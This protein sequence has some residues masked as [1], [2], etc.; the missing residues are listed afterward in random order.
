MHTEDHFERV[1]KLGHYI[2][3]R[4]GAD[5]KV[6]SL[7]AYFHDIRRRHDGFDDQHGNRAAQYLK[8]LYRNNLLDVSE[9][10]FEKLVFACA[11]HSDPHAESDD[12]TIQTCWDADRLDLWRVNNEP[13]P[14][15]LYTDIAKKEEA[16]EYAR[17]LNKK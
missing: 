13:D 14:N 5:K 12:I 9:E 4:N 6:I 16:I 15:L 11:N 1:Q 2:A 17:K 8:I 3:D 7:F 10:Q